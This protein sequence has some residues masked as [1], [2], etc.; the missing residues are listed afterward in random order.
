MYE[1]TYVGPVFYIKKYVHTYVHII[2]VYTLYHIYI[3]II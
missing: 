3:F 2:H 1:S